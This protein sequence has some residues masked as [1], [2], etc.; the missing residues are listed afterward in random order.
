[1]QTSTS[2]QHPKQARVAPFIPYPVLRTH[3]PKSG[4]LESSI[5]VTTSNLATRLSLLSET[6]TTETGSQQYDMVPMHG[7]SSSEYQGAMQPTVM[8]A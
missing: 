7:C 6:C 4:M 8:P 1:M 5:A 2:A 3:Q